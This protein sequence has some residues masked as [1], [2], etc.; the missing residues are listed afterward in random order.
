MKFALVAAEKAN[1]PVAMMCRILGVSR[2]GFYAW[3]SRPPSS[4]AARERRLTAK[5]TAC[6]ARRRGRYG[7]PRIHRELRKEEVVSRKKVAQIMAQN[8]LRA[9]PARRK[10]PRVAPE[11]SGPSA[12]NLLMRNFQTPAPNTVWVMDMK[13]IRT[14]KGWAHLVVVID[15]FSRKVVGWSLGMIADSRLFCKALRVAL[16]TRKPT[17]GLIVHSDQGSQF[18]SKEFQELVREHG[19][20]QSMSRAGD[21][22][23]NA[24]AESFFDTLSAEL[25]EESSFPSE[26]AANRQI[27][28]YIEG[29]YNTTRSHSSLGYMSPSEFE[30]K[31]LASSE[32]LVA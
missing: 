17:A 25:L 18:T 14:D 30:A 29:F 9:R 16:L 32:R 21:C 31:E 23:D 20:I 3:V 27:F 12:P 19:H 11:R 26:V 5:V 6:F 28:A 2:S 13:Y 24:V 4:R 8:G 15:L 7:S 1:F 22:W 10:K